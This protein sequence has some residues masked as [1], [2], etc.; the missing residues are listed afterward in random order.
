MDPPPSSPA[1]RRRFPWWG[2]IPALVPWIWFAVRDRNGVTDLVAVAIPGIGL[3]ALV[4]AAVL[5]GL[6]RFVAGATALSLAGVCVVATAGPRLPARTASPE[7]GIEVVMDNVYRS[8]KRPALAAEAMVARGGDVVVLVE[9]G[10]SYFDHMTAIADRYP[11][12]VVAGEQGVWSRWPIDLL[13]SPP[14]L[15]SDRVARVAVEA[16]G[17]RFVLYVVHLYNP[18]HE[19]TFSEQAAMLD[20]L[21]GAIEDEDLPVVV[22]GDL[23]L[24]DRSAGY[25]QVEGAMV[26]A[27]RTGWWA[28]S[29]F[30]SDAWRPL[31]LRI[32]HIFV[33][34]D[35]CA[36]DAAV[37]RV[38]GSDHEGIESTVGP[39]S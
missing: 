3:V 22:A 32:D 15:P 25:R 34:Q 13:V 23:N 14:G 26:D 6:R 24:S 7:P 36:A 17:A 33:P 35:W 19:T 1:P 10:L 12:S 30:H 2:A 28:A 38:P 20:R 37:F 29:T 9:A 11:Y 39:C 5:L 27:M 21:L 8:G 18:L 4:A 16:D 31:L